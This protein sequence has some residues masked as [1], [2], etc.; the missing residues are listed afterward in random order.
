MGHT[1]RV[2]VQQDLADGKAYEGDVL[3]VKAGYARNFLIPQKKALYAT[4]QNFERLDMQDPDLETADHKRARLEREAQAGEDV[5]LKA[6]DL[7]K[8]YLRNKTVRN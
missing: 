8:Y 6:A 5:D 4:R 1:V 2:I 7:L 3:E